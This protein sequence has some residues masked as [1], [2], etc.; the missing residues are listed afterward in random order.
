MKRNVGFRI[1]IVLILGLVMM[2]LFTLSACSKKETKTSM[3]KDS[4]EPEYKAAL[5]VDGVF[6]L[7]A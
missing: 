1:S 6:A 4:S 3:E 7:C 2:M 5:F